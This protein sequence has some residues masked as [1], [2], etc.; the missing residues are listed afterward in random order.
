MGL[1]VQVYWES[2]V[3]ASDVRLT[4]DVLE[5]RKIFHSSIIDI[6]ALK[7]KNVLLIR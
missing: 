5:R 2:P 3:D 6:Y 1:H 4:S 7:E